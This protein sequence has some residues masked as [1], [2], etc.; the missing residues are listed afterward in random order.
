MAYLSLSILGP[1]Q[2]W[3]ANGSMQPFRTMKERALLAYL[4]VENG[5]PHRREALAEMF[6]PDRPEGIARNNLRQALYGI[7]QAIGEAGFEGIFISNTEYVQANLGDS[8]WLDLAA[9]EIHLE[10]H[11]FH[12]HDAGSPCLNCIQQVRDAVEIYR[13]TFLED[14]TLEGSETFNT[15]VLRKRKLYQHQQFE[16][17]EYLIQEYERLG[18]AFQAATYALQQVSLE[19]IDEAAYRRLM[20]LLARTGRSSTALEWFE[21]CR[22]RLADVFHTTPSPETLALAEQ[23]RQSSL[24]LEVSVGDGTVYQLPEHLTSFVGR[25][26]ELVQISRAL[27]NAS[28][29]LINLTGLGGVG[30]TRLAIQAGRMNLRQFSNGVYFIPLESASST[31]ALFETVGRAI[32]L[33]PVPQQDMRTVLLSY[34]RL[35]HVLLI[36]DNFDHLLDGKG[37][38][39]EILQAAPFVKIILTSRELLRYQAETVIAL[40]GL[41]YPAVQVE[42]DDNA[43]EVEQVSRFDAVRLFLERAERVRQNNPRNGFQVYPTLQEMEAVVRICQIVDG[44]PLGLELAASLARDYSFAQIAEEA[45]RSLDFLTTTLQ[46]IPENQRSLRVSFEYSWDLLPEN[47]REVL[48]KLAVFPSS[49]SVAAAQA[50]AGAAMPWLMRLEDRSLVRRAAY[51]RYILHPLIRQFA[52]QKLRQ[53]S[54]RVEDQALLQHGEFFGAFMKNRARDLKGSRQ[55]EALD[56]IEAELD[57]LRAAWDWAVEHRA[58]NSLEQ[59]SFSVMFFLETR[60][61][62]KEGEEW[63]RNAV[64]CLQDASPAEQRVL[65]ILMSYQGWFSCRLT[66]FEQA[67]SLLQQGLRFMPAD[68][69]QEE[70]RFAHFGLGFLYVWMGRFQ[71]ALFHLT[72][73][74]SLAERENDA[75]SMAWA[76]QSLAEIAFESGQSGLVEGPFSKT[77]ALFE[78]IGELRGC[79]RALNYLGNIALAQKRYAEAR[80]YFERMLLNA[81]KIGDVWGSAGGYSKLGQLA[82]AREDYEQAWRLYQRSLLMFQKMGDQRRSAYTWRELGEAAA[83]L[84]RPEEA[85]QSFFH[86]LEVAAR[87]HNTSLAQDIFTGLAA[88]LL[89]GPQKEKAAQLLL[90]VLDKSMGDPLIS[91]RAGQLIE[92]VKETIPA[93][94]LEKA[95]EKAGTLTLWS[96]VDDFLRTGVHL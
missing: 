34:L 35:K 45:Q 55:A 90:L 5:R 47:E 72:V 50:V 86:A 2:A 20:L 28:C 29:R 56:E 64:S 25:E 89:Q 8:L 66:Y 10:M 65:G 68:D 40:N 12:I 52:G 48:S 3:T 30:K 63:F 53:Y 23:I 1:F 75:W 77:L 22:R 16:A 51:G 41:A 39:L 57:N 18:D 79:G 76:R 27:G 62:W 11:R 84:G 59:A 73:C 37:L 26:M 44:L 80:S 78:G 85:E 93:D 70:R 24:E 15:W 14:V 74:L 6:W 58:V 81:E 67:D 96:V 9:Y 43:L 38:L 61:R 46:D 19:E 88:V 42:N 82:A 71:E 33:V 69:T 17:L 32:G 7:R 36:L 13:G 92:K 4:V 91:N 54:R 31:D 95:R 94:Q 49:F 60:S 87:L 83:V 21:T